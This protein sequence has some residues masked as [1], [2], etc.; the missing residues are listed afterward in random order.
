MSSHEPGPWKV[1]EEDYGDEECV[2]LPRAIVSEA[3]GEIV[4]K[5]EDIAH[6]M[7]EH[8]DT[9]EKAE[10]FFA[11]LQLMV[12]SPILL[13]ALEDLIQE[14]VDQDAN[15]HP[16]IKMAASAAIAKAKEKMS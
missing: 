12:T 13:E 3:T 9:P 6:L 10:R 16:R 14:C 5:P 8:V 4:L 15:I 11:N 2:M 7:G 1:I